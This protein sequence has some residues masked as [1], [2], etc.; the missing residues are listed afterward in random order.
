MRG[1][2]ESNFG[3]NFSLTSRTKSSMSIMSTSSS[4]QTPVTTRRG[5]GASCITQPRVYHF[6]YI[7]SATAREEIRSGVACDVIAII[8]APTI[9]IA[10]IL[11][12]VTAIAIAIAIVLAASR[13]IAVS[14]S[15]HVNTVLLRGCYLL[16]SPASI[17]VRNSSLLSILSDTTY[18]PPRYSTNFVASW[19][20]S[21]LFQTNET[22]IH[23]HVALSP[24]IPYH[25]IVLVALA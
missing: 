3:S 8:P 7:Q 25:T 15:I 14:F 19:D 9:I 10:I 17:S 24:A 13:L 4:P 23:S 20:I 2:S 11:A 22:K 1:C 21:P 6:L 5:S 12:A 18:H 16:T